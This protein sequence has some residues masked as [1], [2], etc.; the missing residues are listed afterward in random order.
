[1]VT[2]RGNVEEGGSNTHRVS[3]TNH[4]EAGVAEGRQNVVYNGGRGS[5][6]ICGN[7]VGNNLHR[8][9]TGC[10]GTVSGTADN[11]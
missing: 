11:V 2:V 5:E 4:G 6:G 10:G 9:K 3:E 8:M 7:S 1:M